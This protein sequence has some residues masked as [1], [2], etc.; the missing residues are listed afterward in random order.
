MEFDYI[1]HKICGHYL[2]AIIN[3]DYTGLDDEEEQLLNQ[4]LDNNFIM[5]SHFDVISEEGRFAFCDV[6]ELMG[7][8]YLVCQYF[9]MK[10]KA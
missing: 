9:P 4:W 5:Y 10:E 2:S 3:D 1:E 7:D 8:V 6:C